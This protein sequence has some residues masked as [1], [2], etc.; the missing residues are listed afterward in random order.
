MNKIEYFISINPSLA[1]K[2][3]KI[4]NDALYLFSDGLKEWVKYSSGISRLAYIKKDLI[5]LTEIDKILYNIE[6]LE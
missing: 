2:L 6:D 3:H 1:Y 5:P 4:E